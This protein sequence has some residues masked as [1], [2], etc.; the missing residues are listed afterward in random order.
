M[1]APGG[2]A[3][4]F[5]TQ[6][7]GASTQVKRI[8]LLSLAGLTLAAGLLYW[9]LP[10]QR[11]GAPVLY[12]ATQNDANK[13]ETVAL[14]Q[15][16]LAQQGLPPVDL[17]IDNAGL[18]AGSPGG[19]PKLL[20]QGASG[21]GGDLIDV[22]TYQLEM[23]QESGMLADLTDDA[24]RGGFS[25][26]MI[27]RALRGD[28]VLDGRQFG[29]PRQSGVDMCWFNR[30][31]FE[32]YHLPEP[33]P[34][35]SWDEFEELG[36]RF[37][38]AANPPGTRQ[39]SYFIDRVWA[40]VLRR[41][42]GLSTY[43]ETGTRCTLDDPRAIEVLKRIYR[44]T[45]DERLM[46]TEQ[47]QQAM[48]S[49]MVGQESA[50]LLFAT[51]RFAMLYEGLWAL[52]ELRHLGDLPL[53]VVEPFTGGFRNALA[54]NGTVA[55]YA[56]TRHLEQAEQFLRFLTSK[57]FNLFVARIGD[58]LPPVPAYARSEAYFHPR[59][60]PNEWQ[61]RQAFSDATRDIGIG[62]TTSPFVLPILVFRID[63]DN[64]EAMLTGLIS[65]EEAARATARRVNEEIAL[66]VRQDPK[67]QPLYAER[68]K[69][70]RQ[71]DERRAAGRPVPAAW[72]SDPFL[73]AYYRAQGWLEKEAVP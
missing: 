17:R 60:H 1:V 11:S 26:D 65:P 19:S 37:V 2:V 9:T 25:T 29:F 14:F 50:F 54:G 40:P 67:L 70:Q 21:M 56:G 16:W 35:W 39:R 48:A 12:W 64:I 31:T 30:A 53:G 34:H 22:Y 55:I 32:R 44:W 23:Y 28:L 8:F 59:G 51:G 66:R 63:H 5:S 20:V 41:G 13:R 62:G 46:P 27:Y 36:R 69:I 24:R 52:M 68:L 58:S 42:L 15:S 71:I 6:T 45:I 57:P 10:E 7:N 4:E 3:V 33:S 73:L 47:E 38:A 18:Q 43:N 49:D 72:I 61:A